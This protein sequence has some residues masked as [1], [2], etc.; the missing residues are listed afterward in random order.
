MKIELRKDFTYSLLVPT[1]M[2]I[3]LLPANGQ[4]CAHKQYILITGN[5]R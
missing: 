4:P 5:K 1:S 3:R 2:G